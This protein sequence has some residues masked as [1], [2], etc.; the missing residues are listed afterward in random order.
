ME[1]GLR[2]EI[3]VGSL[4][5]LTAGHLR[6]GKVKKAKYLWDCCVLAVIWVHWMERNRMI[7][8]DYRGAGLEER[9]H[10]VI[11]FGSFMGFCFLRIQKL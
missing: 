3:P 2:W 8:E 4:A 7:F 5:L 6:F 10:C 9:L 11:F 1:A